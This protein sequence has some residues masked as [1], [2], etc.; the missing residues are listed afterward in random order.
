M[1]TTGGDGFRLGEV[2]SRGAFLACSWTWCIGM[3]LPVYLIHDFGV[4]GWVAFAI[5][6]VAGAMAVGVVHR[7]P[8]AATRF[9]ERGIGVMRWFSVVTILFHLGFF[10]WIFLDQRPA[11]VPEAGAWLVPALALGI[12]WA[13]SRLSSR[14]WGMLALAVIPVALVLMFAAML[15]TSIDVL[16]VPAMEGAVTATG[17]LPLFAVGLAFGFL[18]C[19][20][21]DLTILRVRE[22]TPGTTGT[23]AFI[24][25]F[26]VM[27]LMMITLTAF[28]AGGV[29]LGWFSVY[30]LAHFFVQGTFTIGAH[31]RELR[32]RG[33]PGGKAG[34][35]GFFAVALACAAIGVWATGAEPILNK[36]MS[37][38][39]YESYLWF[40]ALPFPAAAWFLL[41]GR[42]LGR[43]FW[44]ATAAATPLM[45]AGALGGVWW[46][47]PAAVL[48]PVLI[49]AR[50]PRTPAARG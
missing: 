1:N 48:V 23:T 17:A 44:M 10:A 47:V 50:T 28:Y 5:P 8:A 12:G 34:R 32:E 11:G 31:L 25:G 33:W 4:I 35:G 46:A 21:L 24:L 37:R 22:E 26:G 39:M 29:L 49:A 13:L 9:R 6:N 38:V 40:Y 16:A 45:A 43:G 14:G 3:W 30:F 36:P 7:T 41:R 19:P 18:L 42:R 27:F 15:T 2:L 20:H